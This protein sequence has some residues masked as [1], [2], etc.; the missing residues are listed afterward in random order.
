[1]GVE[2]SGNEK[3]SYD[4]KTAQEQSLAAH[5][6]GKARIEKAR[7][8]LSKETRGMSRRRREEFMEK[9]ARDSMR[10][11]SERLCCCS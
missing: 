3:P 7:E 8:E 5:L 10:S 4:W 9:R 6:E 11:D 2:R 1:M